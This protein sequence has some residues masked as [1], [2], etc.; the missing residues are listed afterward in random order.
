MCTGAGFLFLI[1]NTHWWLPPN[2]HSRRVWMPC[3]H[4][5]GTNNTSSLSFNSNDTRH[6]QSNIY[7][8]VFCKHMPM[9]IF[10]RQLSVSN[11]FL[12]LRRCRQAGY[13]GIH[14]WNTQETGSQRGKAGK[15]AMFVI[16]R[17]YLPFAPGATWEKR[18]W[19]N[20]SD[21]VLLYFCCN[22]FS[23]TSK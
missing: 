18:V 21:T 4:K 7:M 10:T 19:P 1:A 13:P 16:N 2:Q 15:A 14:Q 22:A 5:H 20:S 17:P 23:L 9:L 3:K 12:V 11:V 8:H 6:S